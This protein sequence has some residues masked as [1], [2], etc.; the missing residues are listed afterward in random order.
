MTSQ[1]ND[2]KVLIST[3][4]CKVNQ[5][6]SAAFQSD[7]EAAGCSMCGRGEEADIIV[8]NT[9]AVTTKAGAQ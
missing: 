7:F 9:C 2:Q 4:G 8:V 6:E 3:L 1:H 5:Y